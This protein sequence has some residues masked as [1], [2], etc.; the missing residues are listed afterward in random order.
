M[1]ACLGP[2]ASELK[3]G[4]WIQDPGFSLGFRLSALG[5][6]VY[7][8]AAMLLPCLPPQ[9]HAVS[10][11]FTQMCLSVWLRYLMPAMALTPDVVSCFAE[12][13]V[14]GNRI[15]LSEG[16]LSIAFS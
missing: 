11:R 5:F 8:S 12:W 9:R 14:S 1:A 2:L 10:W 4:F 3:L 7:Y 16:A 13:A 6:R 15:A